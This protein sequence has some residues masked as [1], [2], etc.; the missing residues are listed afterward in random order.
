MSLRLH[1]LSNLINPAETI[2]KIGYTR[3]DSWESEVE[4]SYADF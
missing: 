4:L 1:C 3:E 2:A